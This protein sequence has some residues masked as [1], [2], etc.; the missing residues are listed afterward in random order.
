MNQRIGMNIY[1]LRKSKGMTQDDLAEVLNVSKMAVSKWERGLNFPDIEVMCGIADYFD[2]SIDELLGRKEGIKTLNSL[3]HKEKMECLQVAEQIIKYAQLA[4]QEG[5]LYMEEKAKQN[6]GKDDEFLTFVIET[7][8]DGL[9]R[10]TYDLEK[11]EAILHNYAEKEK[12]KESA[13]LCIMGVLMIIDGQYIG[14]IKEE[15]AIRLGKEYRMYIMGEEM[16]TLAL[17]YEEIR[18]RKCKV[19]LLEGIF[20]IEKEIIRKCLRN[21]DNVTLSMAL[22]GASGEVCV[23]ILD[24]LGVKLRKCIYEDVCMYDEMSLEHI[25][26]AQLQMKKLLDCF[27]V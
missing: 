23:Y 15:L 17:D 21:I 7:A 16:E 13:Q 9:T 5:L 20:D 3:Y 22:S 6:K 8:M 4:Q 18:A 19:E 25:H 2:I 11:I 14:T 26:N 10:R 1:I 27:I 12:N 24:F